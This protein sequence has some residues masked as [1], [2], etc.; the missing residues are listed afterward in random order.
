VILTVSHDYPDT[1]DEFDAIIA[2][3]DFD[4]MVDV[5]VD[6]D[7]TVKRGESR[8]VKP[9]TTGRRRGVGVTCRD[10]V[11]E[12]PGSGDRSRKGSRDD[13]SIGGV[14]DE[15]KL[16][17]KVSMNVMHRME[18]MISRILSTT[19]PTGVSIERTDA[20]VLVQQ[21]SVV[22]GL[23]EDTEK[24]K[25]LVA[26]KMDKGDAE[27]ALAIRITRDELFSMLTTIFPSN[28]AIQKALAAYK[29]K[30]PPLASKPGEVS[31]SV[32]V[33]IESRTAEISESSYQV[34]RRKHTTSG[35]PQPLIPARASRLLQLNHRYLKGA[36]GRYY[37]KDLGPEAMADLGS[38]EAVDAD[39]AFDFQPFLPASSQRQE[40]QD[41]IRVPWQYR[42]KLPS[43]VE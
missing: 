42:L 11:L 3:S 10:E 29:K 33:E 34:H 21:L 31:D 9:S 36:D 40:D 43:E 19:A 39:Q 24:L 22:H 6:A 23:Q 37:L 17:A 35:A 16:V 7:G 30:L 32:Q 12:Q 8:S 38:K 4:N 27:R 20:Q 14:L 2:D 25:L 28:T 15:Q 13:D 5:A 1:E 18:G 41:K 26:L